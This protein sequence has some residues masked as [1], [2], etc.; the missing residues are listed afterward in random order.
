VK[1]TPLSRSSTCVRVSEDPLDVPPEG[2]DGGVLTPLSRHVYVISAVTLALLMVLSGRYGYHRDELYYLE[3]G[4]HLAWGYP[5]QPPF[6]PLLARLMS[7]IA[8]GSLVALRLPSAL[9]AAAVIVVTALLTRELKGGQ[10]AQVLSAGSIALSA[11]LLGADHLLSTTA[12]NM[13]AWTLL[14]WLIVRVLRTQEQYLWI[15]G[16][17]V[18]GI[19][20]LNS[21]LVV[22]LIAALFVGVAIVG[23]RH[24]LAS[25]WL[26]AGGVIA[27]VLWS[28]Y[29]VWQARHGWPQL[30]VSRSIAAGGSGSSTSR[31]LL[32]PEQLVL[33]SPY[34]APVWIAGLVRLFRD[35]ALR[36]CR[37][38]G[39]AYL[40]L[41]VVFL[42]TGGKA[43]YLASFLSVLLA[44][45]SQP[46]IDWL[47][48]G[49][50]RL[51]R[52]ALAV[53]LVLTAA[54]TTL[55]TLP[56]LPLDLIHRTPIVAVN[57][58]EGET[59]GWPAFV[60][61]VARVFDQSPILQRSTTS[62]LTSNYGEAG[63]V[64]RYGPS[65]GLPEAFSGQNGF[66]YWGPPPASAHRL[67]AIGFDKGKLAAS[68]GQCQLRT[69]LNNNV[70]VHNQEQGAPVWDCTQLRA[71]WAVV[72]PRFQ[73]LG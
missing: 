63:A 54:G 55:F 66:W 24:V 2:S 16:G 34:L 72:W 13:L 62:I 1:Q 15:V 48:Q 64:D 6:T 65:L 25:R 42:V 30:A 23:P 21:D 32:L 31:Y 36:W 22:F 7:N 53:A 11:L 59:I 27:V 58:D 46:T 19:G 43:Y 57:Y 61:Q 39:A 44:A 28:P 20:L 45:G 3:A 68:F 52:G 12:F 73:V 71:N 17:V 70:Q 8:S 67:L 35:P 33:V 29:L 51:R 50:V 4:R 5:D 38:V 18:A 49:R 60:A 26:W 9:A 47:G 37:A 56:I 14:L 40:V 41:T 69:R 10:A